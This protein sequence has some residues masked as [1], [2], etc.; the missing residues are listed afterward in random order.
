M[1]KMSKRRK[2]SGKRTVTSVEKAR[3]K[4]AK[5]M[6]QSAFLGLKKFD[7]TGEGKYLL[8]ASEKGWN[9]ISQY[10]MYKSGKTI[11]SHRHGRRICET[12]GIEYEGLY[13]IGETLHANFYH[14][15]LDSQTVDDYLLKVKKFLEK[16]VDLEGSVTK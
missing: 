5:T 15:F 7:E 10:I 11:K 13:A 2:R 8:E 3:F 4:R 14:S 12:L 16:E 6:L 9:A 1:L